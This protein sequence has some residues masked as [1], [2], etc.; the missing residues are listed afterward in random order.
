MI[1]SLVETPVADDLMYLGYVYVVER[2]RL[3]GFARRL[4]TTAHDV[5]RRQNWTGIFSLDSLQDVEP[6]YVKFDYKTAYRTTGYTTEQF[7]PMS[8]VRDSEPTLER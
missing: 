7:L 8:T 2:C 1:A 5:A 4:I 3:R 6:L